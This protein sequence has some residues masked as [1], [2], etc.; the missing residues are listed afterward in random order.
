MVYRSNK[1]VIEY[2]G[3]KFVGDV[4]KRYDV[5]TKIFFFF[6]NF[7]TSFPVIYLIAINAVLLSHDDGVNVGMRHR[8][9]SALFLRTNNH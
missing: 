5:S 3:K 7:S 6:P 9:L 4:S 8:L 1:H 2:F